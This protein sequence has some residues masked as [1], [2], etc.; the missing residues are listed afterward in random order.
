MQTSARILVK[1]LATKDTWGHI[2][3]YFW[4]RNEISVLNPLLSH[5]FYSFQEVSNR[6][7]LLFRYTMPASH[8]ADHY[9]WPQQTPW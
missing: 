2:K 7:S 3:H 4:H 5:G 8:L 6:T 9:H 1:K